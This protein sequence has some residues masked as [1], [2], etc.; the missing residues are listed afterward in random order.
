MP[1]I[2]G[3]NVIYGA[4]EPDTKVRIYWIEAFTGGVIATNDPKVYGSS[5]KTPADGDLACNP[6]TGNLYERQGGA[7]WVRID[8]L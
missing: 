2:T 1:V 8:T 4:Q 7:N 6:V 5:G 3:G